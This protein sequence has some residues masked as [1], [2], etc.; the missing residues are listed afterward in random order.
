MSNSHSNGWWSRLP[1]TD[2][3][4]R[5]RELEAEVRRLHARVTHLQDKLDSQEASVRRRECDK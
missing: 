5:I 1:K 2:T 4:A 3:Q